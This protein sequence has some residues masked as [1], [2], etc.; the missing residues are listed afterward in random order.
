V[1]QDFTLEML[2]KTKDSEDFFIKGYFGFA[3][4]GRPVRLKNF[5]I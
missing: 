4:E 2:A 5:T 3:L 1:N